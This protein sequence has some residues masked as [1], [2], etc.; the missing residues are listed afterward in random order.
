MG[1]PRRT[2]QKG[3]RHDLHVQCGRGAERHQ[4]DLLSAAPP[5]GIRALSLGAERKSGRLLLR[6][7][8][9]RHLLRHGPHLGRS[10]L[11]E[12]HVGR[13]LPGDPLLERDPLANRRCEALA[14]RIR[15]SER[16]ST[17][18]AGFQLLVSGPLLRRRALLR[19]AQHARLQQAAHART[20]HL[21]IRRPGSRRCGRPAARKRR[22]GGTPR[23]LCGADAGDRSPALSRTLGRGRSRRRRGDRLGPLRTGGGLE[24]RRLRKNLRHDGQRHAR[25]DLLF[26]IQSGRR[27]QLHGDVSL[28][29]EPGARRRKR[30]HLHRLR[31]EQLRQEVGQGRPA[32]SIQSLDTDR[33]RHAQ[34]AD[35]NGHD[36]PEIPRLQQHGSRQRLPGVPLCRCAA[37][38]RRGDLPPRRQARRN[39]NGG[40]QPGA[41][42]RL[43]SET[44]PSAGLRFQ[45]G[46]LRHAG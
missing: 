2:S 30:R 24:G 1:V 36:L 5:G 20:R 29:S 43:R 41:P 23:T 31:E 3:R 39:G 33:Q 17:L 40:S 8:K 44:H 35:E 28:P 45:A 42:P 18:P 38:L 22:P 32:L 27:Q 4:F 14:A 25:R 21:G 37:L 26:Q 9:L 11:H 19:R 16:R 34:F 12:R 6:T 13:S 15:P 7:G 10:D 46:R